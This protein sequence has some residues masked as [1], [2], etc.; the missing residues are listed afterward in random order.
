MLNLWDTLSKWGKN[1]QD[2][3]IEH[4]NSPYFWL[5]IFFAGLIIGAYTIHALNKDK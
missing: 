4:G 2:W 5:I 1:F 3:I